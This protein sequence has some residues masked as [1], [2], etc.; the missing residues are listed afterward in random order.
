MPSLAPDNPP[1][2]SLVA[3]QRDGDEIA[4]IY[5]K[6]HL[7]PFGEFAPSWVPLSIQV[8]PGQFGFGTRPGDAARAGN[9]PVR[10]R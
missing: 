9:S 4:G 7:V 8:V 10:R 1:R 6:W 3:I 2:N 5:D